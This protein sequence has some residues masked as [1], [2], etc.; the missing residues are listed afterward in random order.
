MMR[1]YTVH[2]IFILLLLAAG[3]TQA[4]KWYTAEV[5]REVGMEPCDNCGISHGGETIKSVQVGNGRITPVTMFY[6]DTIAT[7]AQ[8]RVVDIVSGEPIKGVLIHTQYTCWEDCGLKTAITNEAGFFRLGWVGCNGPG[9]NRPLLIHA[10]SYQ[11]IKTTAVK[12]GAGA[13]LHIELAALP[14]RR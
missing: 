5:A 6:F 7:Y 12:F 14:S 4:Q 9:S 1:R 2:T 10:A 11:T 8:G 3:N 13:Y